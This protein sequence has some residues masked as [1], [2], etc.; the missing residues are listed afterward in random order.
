MTW[1]VED[2]LV[3]RDVLAHAGDVIGHPA[4]SVAPSTTRS[5]PVTKAGSS[6][7]R[8]T[9][10]HATSSDLRGFPPGCCR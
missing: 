9:K 7:A 6:D 5:E 1:N 2:V 3:D 8:R 10:T 4:G